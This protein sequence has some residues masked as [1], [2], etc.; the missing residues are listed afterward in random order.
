MSDEPWIPTVPRPV[1]PKPSFVDR[2]VGL[3][4]R[5]A[6]IALVV[7]IVKPWGSGP[8][9]Q[10]AIPT[11]SP[12]AP[13]TPAPTEPPPIRAGFDDL[14]YDPTIFGTREPTSEWD[15]WPAAYLVTYGFVIQLGGPNATTLPLPASSALPRLT[16]PPAPASPT[17]P[18]D[19]GP[20]WP[21]NVTVAAGYH[22]FLVGINMPLGYGLT[23]SHLVRET[24]GGGP[25]EDVELADWPSPWPNHFSVLGIRAAADPSR[26]RVWTPGTYRLELEFT[27]T[28][29]GSFVGTGKVDRA[30]EIVIEAPPTFVPDASV[31]P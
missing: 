13:P 20:A 27:F 30:I 12:T 22:V 21:S 3:G 10:A 23:N 1:R 18:A 7:L 5:L 15:L 14:A 9:G 17:L 4:V 29:T 8:D 24:A 26:L 25:G 28:G 2:H 19:G 16:L 6:A 11:A 31:A